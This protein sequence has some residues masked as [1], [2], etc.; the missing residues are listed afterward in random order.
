MEI[1][2][3]VNSDPQIV[4]VILSGGSGS[5]LWPLSKPE[6]PKQYLKF[7]ENNKYSLLQNTIKRLNGL[8]NLEN[9][10]IICNEE[11]RFI[12]DD[13][14]SEIDIHP[15][16]IVLEPFGRNTAAAIALA[17]NF[18]LE[19]GSDPL[20]LI[21]SS[22]HIVKD[23]DKFHSSLEIGIELANKG[24]LVSLGVKPTYPETG[25]G[26]IESYE[27]LSK[28]NKSSDI[29]RFVEK[30]GP[31]EAKILIK[32]KFFTWNSGIFIFKSSII[33]NELKKF[34][35]KIFEVCSNTIL[36]KDN[37]FNFHFLNKEV[38]HNCP[39]IPI[40]IAVLEKTNLGSV[41]YLDSGWNDIGNWR[42]VKDN[43][44]K[45]SFGNHLRGEVIVQ[46]TKNCYLRS[47]GRKIVGLGLE[48]LVIVE[49]K[50]AL[51]V[52]NVDYAQNIKSIVND[53]ENGNKEEKQ[54]NIKKYRPWGN[55][56]TI[57]ELKN[58]KVKKLEI[59]SKASLSLQRHSHRSEHWVVVSGKAK[60]EVDNKV[61]YLKENES[62]YIPK[63]IKHR[64]SNP[65]VELLVIVEVQ[66]GDYLGEDD[67][68]R[69]AD[70]YGREIK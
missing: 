44:Q 32:N 15:K 50:D 1:N 51:L 40:D 38:F 39:N 45:D 62:I 53:L 27:K 47:E 7:D 64:L 46:N 23:K 54:I 66:S 70:N 63:K 18:V 13:Q 12:V 61:A 49:T 21:L 42:S 6:Y 11:Q 8:K 33:L 36:K 68:E 69:F 29:K 19:S 58:W 14:L 17:A 41:V 34:Q 65:G 35:P 20:L 22:D 16:S 3:K 37:Q 55:F 24:R 2:N 26:Y 56:T 59:K 48:N 9:P 5:R 60:I 25:Y 31:Q 57:E 67:I 43:S 4:P 28:K 30:P 52:A 10:L